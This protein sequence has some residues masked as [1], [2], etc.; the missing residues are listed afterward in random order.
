MCGLQGP[1]T[2]EAHT[3]FAI[4][5]MLENRVSLKCND[6]QVIFVFQNSSVINYVF[7]VCNLINLC[8]IF[9]KIMQ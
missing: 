2:P 5:S 4:P 1:Y 7:F 8:L 9:F 6:L 3:P